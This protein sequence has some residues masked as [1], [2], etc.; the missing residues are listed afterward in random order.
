M[1]RG[2]EWEQG[3]GGYGVGG[4]GRWG[5]GAGR[6]EWRIGPL[7]TDTPVKNYLPQPPKYGR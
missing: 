5:D 4:W 2:M 1:T 6:G 3:G 7:L